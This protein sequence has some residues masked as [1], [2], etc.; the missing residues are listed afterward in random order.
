MAIAASTSASPC[1]HCG[2]P[3]RNDQQKFCC[4]GCE[5]IYAAI[6]ELGL[7]HFYALQQ[8][9]L[10]TSAEQPRQLGYTELD[11][12][13]LDSILE[14][15]HQGV[16][17]EATLYIDGIHCAGC[18]WIL[19][20][21]PQFQHGVSSAQVLLG[22]GA[23][24]LRYLSD[25]V[26]LSDIAR[27]IDRLGYPA[28]IPSPHTNTLSQSRLSNRKDLLRIAAAGFSTANTM[29]L[30]VSLFQGFFTG[31]D[32]AI[33]HFFRWCS[34]L[35]SIPALWAAWPMTSAAL[36]SLRHRQL[37][38]DLPIVL[39]LW[40]AFS[41]SVVNTWLGRE[42]VYF[43]SLCTIIFLLLIGRYLQARAVQKAQR[44]SRR[45]WAFFPL[46]ARLVTNSGSYQ[47]VP[48]RALMPGM[49]VCVRAQERI[50]ADLRIETGSSALDRSVLTGESLPIQVAPG[51]TA[52]AGTLNIESELIGTVMRVGT[53][54][55]M[56]AILHEMSRQ[57]QS[58]TGLQSYLDRAAQ[59]YM[60]ALLIASIAIVYL[61]L[62]V[63]IEYV[64]E[65]LMALS[66]VACP[67]ALAFSLPTTMSIALSRAAQAGILIRSA[68]SLEELARI[69]HVVLDK[70]GTVTTGQ[71]KISRILGAPLE[72][73][74]QE[75]LASLLA[76][77]AQHPASRAIAQ[78]LPS[79]PNATALSSAKVH[80]GLGVSAQG[81][82][83][84]PLLL[85]SLRFV[86]AAQVQVPWEL[87]EQYSY[88][89]FCKAD[90]AICG[91]ELHDDLAP[92]AS[93]LVS[94][95]QAQSREVY[96]LSGDRES[97]AQ[98]CGKAL[99]IPSKQVHGNYSPEQKADAVQKLPPAVVI[100]D[101]VN[102]ALALSKAQ[103]AIGIHG[104][105]EAVLEVADV[106]VARGGTQS[107]R[108]CFAG[109]RA[110]MNS[111]K[112]ILLFS[113]TYNSIGGLCAVLGL[114]TPLWA[115][116]L[117]P[118]SSLVVISHALGSRYFE[119]IQPKKVVGH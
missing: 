40:G 114:I 47:P 82:E 31:I 75:L 19:E 13:E 56:G 63:G 83:G 37:H 118:L 102:D 64:C 100:G 89:F 52:E 71:L 65:Q 12:P 112:R 5:T 93:E 6:H 72:E 96:L 74:N 109:A 22:E 27:C 10:A 78:F 49:R 26:K 116:V 67:C 43:D 90:Q 54:T 8:G 3:L 23:L 87:T 91:F 115:A 28:R 110:T 84:E 111:L 15:T 36:H 70:T 86:E 42:Y 119:D 14:R 80:P 29:M 58:K 7:E 25:E 9:K 101:G 24:R 44:E 98:S 2:L 11:Q 45:L 18:L 66:M 46:E 103:V 88:V 92:G 34:A 104:G 62:P 73:K 95:L 41:L 79:T 59:G 76:I 117:M 38:L 61:W 50:P 51:D 106:F 97:V 1:Q 4:A 17:T 55:R 30:A 69:R 108:A 39:A 32:P 53:H 77:N 85:G 57:E 99:G 113:V 48:L 60:L 33:G 81:P 107:L 105:I 94:E 21:L 20:K 16:T 35:L 68:N